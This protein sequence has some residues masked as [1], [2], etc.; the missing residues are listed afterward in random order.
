MI[1]T[2]EEIENIKKGLS[3]KYIWNAKPLV[4]K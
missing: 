4:W 3:S 1:F 2:D